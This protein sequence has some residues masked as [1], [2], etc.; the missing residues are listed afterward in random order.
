MNEGTSDEL[1]TSQGDLLEEAPFNEVVWVSE[2]LF[3]IAEAI[4]RS[5]CRKKSTGRM[6]ESADC[7]PASDGTLASSVTVFMEYEVSS[8]P[9][10]VRRI[11]TLCLFNAPSSS[12]IS[13]I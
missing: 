8:L 9:L 5:F 10:P 12:Y 2:F 3:S 1:S 4:A 13:T 11:L 7:P 6:R